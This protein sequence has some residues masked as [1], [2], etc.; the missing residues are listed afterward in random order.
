VYFG[1]LG[2]CERRQSGLG[3]RDDDPGCGRAAS[4]EPEERPE[5]ARI[6]V[7]KVRARLAAHAHAE[8]ASTHATALAESPRSRPSRHH[9]RP[10]PGAARAA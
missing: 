9:D 4:H 2:V 8:E 3:L 5:V 6:I 10:G 7:A 1:L